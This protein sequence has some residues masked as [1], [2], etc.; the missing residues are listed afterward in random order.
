MKKRRGSITVLCIF[1]ALLLLTGSMIG[2][3]IQRQRLTE[4]VEKAQ[5]RKAELVREAGVLLREHEALFDRV[6]AVL[7]QREGP[8]SIRREPG[9]D[10]FLVEIREDAVS[11]DDLED[12]FLQTVTELYELVP[13][14]IC[15]GYADSPLIYV[16]YANEDLGSS[17]LCSMW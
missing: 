13:S 7:E 9:T 16:T 10:T 8:L 14:E 11:P 2:R 5:Q 15:Y 6:A 1:L 17:L 12:G 4:Q 3:R